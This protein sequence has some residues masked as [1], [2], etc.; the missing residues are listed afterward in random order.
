MNSKFSILHRAHLV[1]N[2]HRRSAVA[3]LSRRGAGF[4]DG[5]AR[6]RR[7]ADDLGRLAGRSNVLGGDLFAAAEADV[8]LC[9]WT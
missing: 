4:V 3:G 7:R 1:Q 9:R 2:D 6:Q 5:F 8:D